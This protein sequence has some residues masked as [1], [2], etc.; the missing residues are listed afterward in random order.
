MSDQKQKIA[1]NWVRI[2]MAPLADTCANSVPE[3]SASLKLLC[4]WEIWR[5][6]TLLLWATSTNGRSF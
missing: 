6:W 2:A 3:T 4:L 5:G 1:L